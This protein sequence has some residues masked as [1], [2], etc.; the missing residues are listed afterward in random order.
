M[1]GNVVIRRGDRRVAVRANKGAARVMNMNEKKSVRSV[2]GAA[3]LT[4][5]R[6]K[7]RT[8]TVQSGIQTGRAGALA[9]A[10]SEHTMKVIA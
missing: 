10:C 9:V 4:L 1:E 8:F 7:L 2:C 3:S 5:S 6:E